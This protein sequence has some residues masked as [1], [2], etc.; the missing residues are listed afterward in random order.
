MATRHNNSHSSDGCMTGKDNKMSDAASR[1]TQLS[2]RIFSS[3]FHPYIPYSKH[4]CLL[5]LLSKFRGHLITIMHSNVST[6]VFFHSTPKRR[7]DMALIETILH[8]SEYHIRS[9]RNQITH[10]FPPELIWACPH[11]NSVHKGNPCQEALWIAITPLHWKNNRVCGG[12]K[13]QA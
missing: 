12:R 7:H 11:W 5:Q 8:L 10:P 4:W 3:H 6:K 9:P 2:D 1:I 13:I